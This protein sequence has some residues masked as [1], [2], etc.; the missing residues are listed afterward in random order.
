MESYK[1]LRFLNVGNVFLGFL[2]KRPVCIIFQSD[3]IMTNR[4]F[5]AFFWLIKRCFVSLL[6]QISL[7]FLES[8]II[9]E[10]PLRID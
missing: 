2:L 3:T 4:C 8:Q 1:N 10:Y 7:F 9:E 6:T 5:F